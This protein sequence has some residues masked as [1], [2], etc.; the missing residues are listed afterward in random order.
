M[1]PFHYSQEGWVAS[2]QSP[3]HL[4]PGQAARRCDAIGAG[5]AGGD[6]A[7]LQLRDPAAESGGL[8]PGSACRDENRPQER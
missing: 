6:A 3:L 8:N 4:P 5:P 2:T 1:S 7:A